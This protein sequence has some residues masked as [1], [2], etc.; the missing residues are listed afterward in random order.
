M[1][2]NVK[3]FVGDEE[4]SV[5]ALCER[6]GV[7]HTK[8]AKIAIRLAAG[9]ENDLSVASFY[10]LWLSGSLPV[11]PR[12]CLSRDLYWLH[13][14][15]C[16]YNGVP[17]ITETRLL[18][19]LPAVINKSRRSIRIKGVARTRTVLVPDGFEPLPGEPLTE[20]LGRESEAFMAEIEE[21]ETMVGA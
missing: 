12:P 3:V 16:K 9:Q 19:A 13:C 2:S 1:T 6:L 4:V 15:W 17:I 20:C 21:M 7:A 18:S 8:M 14:L 10:R 5:A 11:N